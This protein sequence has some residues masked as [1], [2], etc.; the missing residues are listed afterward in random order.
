VA[1]VVDSCDDR[2]L[3]L[4]GDWD[5]LWTE[6][7]LK[8]GD[9]YFLDMGDLE[10]RLT[11]PPWP[12]IKGDGPYGISHGDPGQPPGEVRIGTDVPD[13]AETD[14]ELRLV[15]DPRPAKDLCDVQKGV[16]E[17]GWTLADF[18]DPARGGPD[19]TITDPVDTIVAGYPAIQVTV[20][21]LASCVVGAFEDSECCPDDMAWFKHGRYW[22]VE[23]GDRRMLIQFL[24]AHQRLT[25]EQ[26]AIG[27]K[28]LE[29]LRLTP[30]TP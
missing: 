11:V 10:A 25:P 3:L 28:L 7:G 15:L 18:A 1:P 27:M 2:R 14:Y 13:K 26:L 6:I 17:P 22:A 21:G 4:A 16:L 9:Q 5:H 12:N 30:S 29:S 8:I 23:V 24:R 20:D 19:A